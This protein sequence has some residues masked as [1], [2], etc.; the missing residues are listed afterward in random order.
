MSQV[1]DTDRVPEGGLV[2]IMESDEYGR[3][4]FPC[5]TW[6]DAFATIK[7]L[8][9]KATFLSDGVFRF[10]GICEPWPHPDYDDP[11]AT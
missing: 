4:E 11:V 10:I 2:V 7:Q 6:E 5:E 8:H 9:N 1:W 3:E